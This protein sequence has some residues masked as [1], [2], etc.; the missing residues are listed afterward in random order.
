MHEFIARAMMTKGGV[1]NDL[2]DLKQ[3]LRRSQDM[4]K[5]PLHRCDGLQKSKH[6][7]DNC[8]SKA[9]NRQ[10]IK[11]AE[12]VQNTEGELHL[13]STNRHKATVSSPPSTHESPEIANT[14]LK[15]TLQ[16]PKDYVFDWGMY[17]G[18]Y[19]K[20]VADIRYQYLHALGGRDDLFEPGRHEGFKEAYDYYLPGVR[21]S[22]LQRLKGQ[23]GP[24]I[25]PFTVG[26]VERV[27]HKTLMKTKY[28]DF[29]CSSSSAPHSSSP[30][31]IFSSP[32]PFP[33]ESAAGPS[34][35]APSS[36]PPRYSESKPEK[37]RFYDQMAEEFGTPRYCPKVK[38][39]PG[40][41]AA[42]R[43]TLK[44]KA[45]GKAKAH[46]FID[47]MFPDCHGTGVTPITGQKRG[48]GRPRKHPL[49]EE[50]SAKKQRKLNIIETI[51]LTSD[52]ETWDC[53]K[54][55]T[56]WLTQP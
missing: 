16:H 21:H 10:A 47:I 15:G 31:A 12:D 35:S 22:T 32:S 27:P 42:T 9:E 20:D 23:T 7:P 24:T 52:N 19:I 30:A 39:A 13:P 45:K 48:R 2:H 53:A 25:A 28:S 1:Q 50:P 26:S 17:A 14:C 29:S 5:Q 51:D 38:K 11:P 18:E 43:K 6:A 37:P 41:E 8:I 3:Q 40:I 54:P 33:R 49:P 4:E 55:G 46:P 44:G 56:A 34:S 36:P